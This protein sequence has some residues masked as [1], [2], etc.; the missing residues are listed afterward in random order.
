MAGG[1]IAAAVPRRGAPWRLVTTLLLATCVVSLTALYAAHACP[2]GH[3]SHHPAALHQVKPGSTFGKQALMSTARSAVTPVASYGHCCGGPFSTADS[4][5]K[6]GCCSAGVAMGEA[7]ADAPLHVG[8]STSY[9]MGV[10]DQLTSISPPTH[11]RPP[12]SLV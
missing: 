9:I 10:Q 5:C 8:L 4:S 2:T 1:S 6:S 11:F 7:A 3:Q 12:P